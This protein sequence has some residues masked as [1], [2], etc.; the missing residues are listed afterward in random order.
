MFLL[1]RIR[2]SNWYQANPNESL[3]TKQYPE[4][5]SGQ[6]LTKLQ[7]GTIALKTGSE[8]ILINTCVI[9]VIDGYQLS[10]EPIF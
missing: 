3:N 10:L 1:V 7:G 9:M 4:S 2:I 8:I 5:F 6:Y